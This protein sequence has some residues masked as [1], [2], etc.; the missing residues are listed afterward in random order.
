MQVSHPYCVSDLAML[1]PELTL[2]LPAKI[3]AFTGMDVMTHAI[4]GVTSTVVEPIGDALGFHAIRMV[5]KYLPIAVKEPDNVWARGN[6][7]IA[8]TVAGLCFN[9]TM[10]GAVHALAHSLGGRYGIPH[11]LANGIMLPEVM[12]F[13]LPE[14]A[15]RFMLV[16]DA[17]GL[18]VDGLDPMEAGRMAVQAIRDLRKE[19]GLT[20]TLKDFG[21]PADRESLQ[22]LLEMASC[23]GQIAYNPRTLEE[24]DIYNL[25]L[26]AM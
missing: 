2:K 22:P 17:M 12:E 13:N 20:Q 9:N 11:G 19:I 10:T 5:C 26:K 18:P 3:T 23:D 15:E 16:A 21:V 8:S 7:L 14:R 4:E 24:E 6:M 1:D 25:Y